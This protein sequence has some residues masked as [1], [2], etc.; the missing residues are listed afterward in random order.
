MSSAVSTCASSRTRNRIL[1]PSP[2][3]VP[4]PRRS[5]RD[6]HM[7][8]AK[9]RDLALVDIALE[10]VLDVRQLLDLCD[11]PVSDPRVLRQAGELRFACDSTA[12]FAALL[13]QHHVVPTLAERDSSLE[14]RR[15]T[16]DDQD[17]RIRDLRG[18]VFWMPTLAPL[19]A[20][21]RV[22]STPDRCS[23]L[24][25]RVAD[26]AAIHSRISSSRPSAIFCGKNGSAIDGLA[27]PMRSTTPCRTRR[28]IVSGE[29][30]RRH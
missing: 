18:D 19:L 1:E 8:G 6:H 4:P 16:A 3:S 14:A 2:R 22:L 30:K 20:H 24:V 12:E 15:S 25:T 26:V 13:G 11:S 10:V 7:I 23:G 5:C 21:R 29:V 17:R 27:D 28:N 9:V